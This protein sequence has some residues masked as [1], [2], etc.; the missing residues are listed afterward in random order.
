MTEA[1]WQATASDFAHCRRLH[2][3]HGTTY[4]FATLRLPRLIRRR[5][6]ALYGFVRTADE[7]V[8]NPGDMTQEE[9]RGKLCRFEQE[10]Q[11]A[12][13]GE[14]PKD[15][16]LRAFCASARE[17]GMD[18]RE[19][20]LFLQ[21][22]RQDLTVDRYATYAD[23][24]GYMRGSAAAVGLMMCRF[25]EAPIDKASLEGA[26]SL[27]NAMQLT[28][29]IR[30]MGEDA[31]RGRIY[32][33]QEWLR[34]FAVSEDRIMARQMSSEV[35]QLVEHASAKA[36]SLYEAADPEIARLPEGIRLGVR[37]ARVLYA[38]ILDK[39]AE[40]GGDVLTQRAR[41]TQAEKMAALAAEL[42][43]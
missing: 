20:R 24:E 39:V 6:H 35:V 43:G 32:L 30:D 10:M 42:K 16:A 41:T 13:A 25:A 26:K 22:M 28:N 8:D 7:W 27:G 23:L 12:F 19:P 9:V 29:F 36:R 31:A 14:E 17:A 2:R 34:R 18:E 37:L 4:Y 33:P 5:V 15:P 40:N 3:R 38:K 11:G 21:A 1:P